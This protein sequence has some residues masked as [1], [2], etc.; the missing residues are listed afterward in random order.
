MAQCY[1]KSQTISSFEDDSRRLKII[2][3]Y[4]NNE[5]KRKITIKYC[6][7]WTAS[8]RLQASSDDRRVQY[9]T[10]PHASFN[11]MLSQVDLHSSSAR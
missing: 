11:I 5:R 7:N 3:S 4:S 6:I 2:L 8:E 10:R 1:L 9:T